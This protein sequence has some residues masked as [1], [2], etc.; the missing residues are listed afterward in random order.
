MLWAL[1]SRMLQAL[2][3][4]QYQI[5]TDTVHYSDYRPR[6]GVL[7]GVSSASRWWVVAG[8][9]TDWFSA[10][11]LR[12]S[13]GVIDGERIVFA[14]RLAVIC[15]VLPP[16]PAGGGSLQ[17]RVCR[18]C[19][20]LVQACTTPLGA[21]VNGAAGC[22]VPCGEQVVGSR[23]QGIPVFVCSGVALTLTALR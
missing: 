15:D 18:R 16:A 19:L 7:P 10:V 14:L 11:A 20:T 13:A 9:G 1:T 17:S 6:A 2:L 21:E 4:H 12:C 5:F 8:T 22:A 3:C 23:S